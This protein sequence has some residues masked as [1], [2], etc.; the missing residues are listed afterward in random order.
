MK[1]L[2]N[3]E[4]PRQLWE[5]LLTKNPFRSPFQ[6]P[7]FFDFFNTVPDQHVVALAV[8]NS[9]ELLAL[10]VITLQKES[11]IKSYFS[12]RAVI[13]GGPVLTEGNET[14]SKFLLKEITK[15]LKYKA[16][17][18]ETRNL[19]D[20]SK[21][22]EIYSKLGW[23]YKPYLNFRVPCNS[24]DIIW[25][26]LNRLRKRQIKKAF[27]NGVIIKEAENL[28]EVRRLFELLY[29]LYKHRIKKPV[30][31]WDF[32][33]LFY[34][35]NIGKVF[36]V[37]SGNEVIGGHFCPAEYD[38]IFDWYG[39]GLDK[40]YRDLSPSTM[41]VYA[42]LQYGAKNGYKYF[43][44]MGAGSIDEKYGVRDFK[45]QFGG[46]LIEFG[47]FTKV[48]NPFLYNIG[49]FGFYIMAKHKR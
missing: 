14:A 45:A 31:T 44:F 19:F 13:Y 40:K 16:I 3:N 7:A 21:Q 39:C 9:K 17:Y 26:N 33:Q 24:E 1:L 32:F 41:A 5:Q 18:I 35:R 27:E 43:D 42:A 22:K 38:V 37:K 28:N 8:E 12:R 15:F 34:E 47:R 29:S 36:I 4:I 23:V 20:Y 46:E 11:G 25:N 6:T 48:L 49:K 30:F 10:A 2:V